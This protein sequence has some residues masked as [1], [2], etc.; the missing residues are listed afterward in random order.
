MRALAIPALAAA[1]VLLGAGP[2]APPDRP[3]NF[4]SVDELK[5]LLDRRQRV[6]VID[7]RHWEQYVKQHIRGA[8][9]MPIRVISERGHEIT[10]TGVAVFY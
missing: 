2:A 10:K 4:I 9:S 5:S 1:L 8:R 3:V 6:D 7:V